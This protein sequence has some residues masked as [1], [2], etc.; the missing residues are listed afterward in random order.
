MK[1]K[2]FRKAK[3]ISLLMGFIYIG[4]LIWFGEYYLSQPF[5]FIVFSISTVLALLITPLLSD[6]LLK[7]IVIR[8]LGT[9]LGIIGIVNNVYTMVVD[10]TIPNSPDIPAFV[11]RIV[12]LFVLIIMIL[13]II[14]PQLED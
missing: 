13:R 7:S 8:M 3:A 2:T 11:I 14:N 1:K 12:I 4:G 6:A 5:H 10:L 9:L